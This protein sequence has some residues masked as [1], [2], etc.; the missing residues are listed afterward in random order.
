MV[1]Q[2]KRDEIDWIGV[3]NIE[4]VWCWH[5]CK[6]LFVH[7]C[8]PNALCVCVLWK[9]AGNPQFDLLNISWM[10]DALTRTQNNQP[11]NQVQK[12]GKAIA[13]K[14]TEKKCS[15]LNEF[16]LLQKK[17]FKHFQWNSR[18]ST[19]QSNIRST[20]YWTFDMTMYRKTQ[21]HTSLSGSADDATTTR[22][23]KL[24]S[25]LVIKWK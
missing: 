11:I 8:V 3:S 14:W 13:N 16:F 4:S 7:E 19:Q 24:F 5:M 20:F 17:P 10:F 9:W 22:R 12:H 6:A 21:W 25:D 15:K 2:K 1:E 18:S 23:K